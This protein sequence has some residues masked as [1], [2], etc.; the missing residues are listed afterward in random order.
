MTSVDGPMRIVTFRLGEQLYAA[1]IF[2][3]ERVLRCEAVRAIPEMPDW[4]EGVIDHGGEVVPVIDLRRRFS[5]AAG[6]PGPHARL[7]V[8]ASRDAHA[9]L[10]VDSVLDVRPLV[11]AELAEAP[12]LFR[13]LG[14]E[15]IKGLTR[16]QGALV[17]VLDIDRL[18]S[19]TDVISLQ[20]AGA[21]PE[22]RG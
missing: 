13:G 22:R 2:S 21:T 20:L 11:A 8:C 9:A 1:D 5:M 18:L 19:S 4:M 17:V 14:G 10:L 15:Y 16:R 7:I 3:V 12:K 6:E